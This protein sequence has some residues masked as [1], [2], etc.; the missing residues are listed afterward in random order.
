MKCAIQR[1]II[2]CIAAARDEIVDDDILPKNPSRA[3]IN[4]KQILENYTCPGR[5]EPS[6]RQREEIIHGEF[7]CDAYAYKMSQLCRLQLSLASRLIIRDVAS[8]WSR[9][10]E[11]IAF[12]LRSVAI[13]A[14]RKLLRVCGGLYTVCEQTI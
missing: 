6:G 3:L 8:S 11:I 13:P 5:K 4:V 10:T 14:E 7:A 1:K 12:V 9:I 2:S